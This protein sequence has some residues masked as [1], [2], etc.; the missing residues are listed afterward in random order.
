MLGPG[1]KDHDLGFMP[2][3]RMQDEGLGPRSSLTC[4]WRVYTGSGL[5]GHHAENTMCV[6]EVEE[7]ES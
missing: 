7:V 5:L 6:N 2:W 4:V 3:V 1:L